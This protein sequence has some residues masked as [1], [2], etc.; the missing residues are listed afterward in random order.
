MDAMVSLL[1]VFDDYHDDDDELFLQNGWSIKGV[2]LY[3]KP[4]SEQA[5][6]LRRT[7]VQAG[8]RFFLML[9]KSKKN[10]LGATVWIL[11]EV[12]ADTKQYFLY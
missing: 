10:K 2:G 1:L 12:E 6:H 3:F 9:N 8:F 7:W 4:E 11:S 5:L